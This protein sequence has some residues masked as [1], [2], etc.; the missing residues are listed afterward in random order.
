M[1][2][3][4]IS[5]LIRKRMK[6]ADWMIVLRT[7]YALMHLCIQL[8]VHVIIYFRYRLFIYSYIYCRRHAVY[9]EPLP[10]LELGG[11]WSSLWTVLG[12]C[13]RGV[14]VPWL[15]CMLLGRFLACSRQV[16]GKFWK[17]MA[18]TCRFRQ[19]CCKKAKIRFWWI[20]SLTI[21]Q[22]KPTPQIITRG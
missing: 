11:L 13:R 1:T 5:K 2:I 8:F 3:P 15:T 22:P 10:H 9:R 17:I 21:L 14:S 6:G 7:L 19:I 20:F 4:W 18:G 12:E 16:L